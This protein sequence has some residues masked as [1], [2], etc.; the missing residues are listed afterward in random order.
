M[1]LICYF[2][3]PGIAGQTVFQTF[4]DQYSARRAP[5]LAAAQVGM[6]NTAFQG[7]GQ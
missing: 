1:Q 2:L 3:F 6:R 4:K 7:R 5:A